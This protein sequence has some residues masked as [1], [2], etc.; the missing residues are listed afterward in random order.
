MLAL[1]TASLSRAQK[2]FEAMAHVGLVECTL[3]CVEC[4][5]LCNSVR[6]PKNFWVFRHG[7]VEIHDSCE[8]GISASCQTR[9]RYGPTSGGHGNPV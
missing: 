4:R 2:Q 8:S 6:S 5:W 9:F 1:A 3:R 7:D